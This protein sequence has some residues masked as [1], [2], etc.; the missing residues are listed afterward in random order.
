MKSAASK[1]PASFEAALQELERLVQTLESG[2]A[3]L[4][5]SLKAYERGIALLKQC[6]ETLAQAE[7]KVRILDGDKLNDFAVPADSFAEGGTD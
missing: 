6:Q 7:Q 1:P 4:E 5:D 2:G 3:P